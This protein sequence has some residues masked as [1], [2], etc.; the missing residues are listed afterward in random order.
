MPNCELL[1]ET[2]VDNFAIVIKFL[3]ENNLIDEAVNYLKNN[4]HTN[5]RVSI[6]AVEDIQKFLSEKYPSSSSSKADAIINCSHSHC[7]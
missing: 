6:E 2:G 5:I 1:T 7:S 4:G 3:S